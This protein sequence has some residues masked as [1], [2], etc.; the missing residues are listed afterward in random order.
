MQSRCSPHGGIYTAPRAPQQLIRRSDQTLFPSRQTG[1]LG[2]DWG[3]IS[4]LGTQQTDIHTV[5]HLIV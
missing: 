1:T 3:P 5:S 2:S 4:H